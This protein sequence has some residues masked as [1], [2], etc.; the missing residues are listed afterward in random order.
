MSRETSGPRS[1]FVIVANEV[2]ARCAATLNIVRPRDAIG[3]VGQNAALYR[4][5]RFLFYA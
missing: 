4:P 3:R 2:I 1:F 5:V